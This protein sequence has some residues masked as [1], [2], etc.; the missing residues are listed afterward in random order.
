[1]EDKDRIDRLFKALSEN[2]R[3]SIISIVKN[4]PGIRITE[5][6]DYFPTSRFAVMK[7]VNILEDTGI[8]LPKKEGKNKRLYLNTEP[9]KFILDKWFSE[10]I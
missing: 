2:N 8:I 10:F 7:H 1:M 5:L 9:L 3:R 4:E 6:C